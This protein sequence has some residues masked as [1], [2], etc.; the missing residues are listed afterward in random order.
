M[1]L[2][3]TLTSPQGCF[4]SKV[5][6]AFGLYVELTQSEVRITIA[7]LGIEVTNS[8]GTFPVV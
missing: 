1:A 3:V 2:I 4:R 8:T 5:Q 6:Q 7:L